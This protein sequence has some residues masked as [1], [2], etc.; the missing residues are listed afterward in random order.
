[1]TILL[2]LILCGLYPLLV[3]LL[4]QALFPFEADG[5]ILMTNSH[6]LGSRIIG[7]KFTQPRYFHGRPSAAGASGYD[8]MAS[9]GSNYG[10]TNKKLLIRIEAEIKHII[11]DN[12]GITTEQ[13]PVDLLT[14]SGSGL[15]PHIS[16]A[17]ARLQSKRVA[18]IRAMREE[19]VQKL[20]EAHTESSVLGGAGVNVLELNLAL[21]RLMAKK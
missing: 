5:Q 2:A 19:E 21:D 18:N 4:G 7:Q 6:P 12:P 20:I 14:A 3:T 10:V 8:P 11:R 17:A 9:G 1:M 13:I 15:D 16:Q